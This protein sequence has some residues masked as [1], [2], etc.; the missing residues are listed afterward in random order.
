ME[1]VRSTSIDTALATAL[2]STDPQAVARIIALLEELAQH[3]TPQA[4][5]RLRG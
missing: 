2:G 3:L 5:T 1:A 4:L